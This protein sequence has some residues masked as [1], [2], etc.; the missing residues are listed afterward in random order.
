MLKKF[1]IVL[2]FSITD[3]FALDIK[4]IGNDRTS[5]DVILVEI[6][7]F[8]DPLSLTDIKRRLFNLR[9]F[10]K[11]KVTKNQ[12][13]L[14]IKVEE[15]WTTIPIFQVSGGGGSSYFSVGAYD[16]NVAGL[17]LEMGAQYES[18]NNRPAGVMWFRKPQ[19][20]KNRTLRFGADFWNINRIRFL[21]NEDGSDNGAF[22]LERTRINTFIEKTYQDDTFLFRLSLDHQRDKVSEE[23][24]SDKQLAIND[25]NSFNPHFNST[26]NFYRFTFHWGRLDYENYLVKGSRLL[27][28]NSLIEENLTKKNRFLNRVEVRFNH[29]SLIR[30]TDNFAFQLYATQTNQEQIQYQNYIGGLSEVRGYRDGQFISNGYIQSNIE[31]RFN[32]YEIS[33]GLLQGCFFSDQAREFDATDKDPLLSSGVGVRII[34]P[35]IFRFV[36]RIDYAQTH[37]RFINQ[38]IS[39]GV[40]QFF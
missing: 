10:S 8:L 13:K 35:K 24:L 37:T 19:F 9:L 26:N 16:I 7:D 36:G 2:I 38:N 4:I 17:N 23:E 39:F 25:Q 31:Y 18:L 28:R 15:R 40:Q 34:S 30:K 11:V 20:L 32:L 5:D 21:F 1:I 3:S 14:F 12:N 33:Y 6:K 29:Y 27:F 22:T